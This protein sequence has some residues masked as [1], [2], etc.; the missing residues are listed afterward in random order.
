MIIKTQI[1]H[2][3]RGYIELFK[4]FP[5][6]KSFSLIQLIAY[7]GTWFSN[8]AIYTLLI[9]LKASPFV[10]SLVVAFHFIPTIIQAP[11]SG[12]IVDRTRPKKLMGILLLVECMSTLMLLNIVTK[13]DI[14]L[15]ML[16]V[17]VRMSASSLFFATL[18]SLLPKI[19]SGTNLQKA[20]EIHSIIWSLTFTLGM[21]IGGVVV[22][23]VGV[24]VAFVLDATLFV[25]AFLL[26]IR[27]RF[28]IKIAISHLSFLG[29]IGEGI[30]YLKSHPLTLHLMLL[31][32]IVGVTVFDTLV[33]LLADF[34]YRYIIS[35]PLAIGI[36]NSARAI[37]LVV[38]PLVLG[39]WIN[40][41][42]LF[43][44]LMAQGVAIVLWGFVQK[45]FYVGLVGMFLVG[46]G[47]TTLWS[48]TYALLQERVAPQFLGRVIAYNDMLFMSVTA[49]VTLFTGFGV[50]YLGLEYITYILGACFF[51]GG[52][53]CRYIV[54]PKIR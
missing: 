25:V 38:G 41:E 4:N 54:Y 48:Y 30:G 2:G 5:L 6:I 18:M 46:L 51:V 9:E 43:W 10:I 44:I 23:F 29:S 3:M 21:A 35:V 50:G 37:G 19:V 45:D 39:N 33:T 28:D 15:L 17:F 20:N 47:T 1:R 31:H 8:V 12:A 14:W 27:L 49:V 53:Y 36:T 26:L 42:R 52:A 24:Y 16:L 22:H 34:H 13:D 32:S 11:F 7:F 40:K